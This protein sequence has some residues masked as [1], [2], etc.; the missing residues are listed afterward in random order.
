MESITEKEAQL[1]DLE[2][3]QPGPVIKNEKGMGENAKAEY[4]FDKICMD[5][6]DPGAF[7]K[8]MKERPQKHLGD[9]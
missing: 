9:L 7:I 3:S 5:R 1:K 4:M 2:I 6:R 8:I